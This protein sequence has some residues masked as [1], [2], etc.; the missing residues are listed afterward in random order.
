M[1]TATTTAVAALPIQT[2]ADIFAFG[3]MLAKSNMFGIKNPADGVVIAATC[4]QEKISFLKFKETF[5][6][7]NGVPAI[8]AEA[9]LAN[10]LNLGGE[11][12]ILER[13][14]DIVSIK[15]TYKKATYISTLKWQ[16][17][18]MEDYTKNNRGGL[19]D[20]WSTPRRRMQMMW[21][22]VVSDG[23]RVVCPLATRGSYTPEEVMDFE[24]LQ[25]R[26]V[27][28]QE[29]PRPVAPAPQHQPL[30]QP[31]PIAEAPVIEA[32]PI[33]QPAPQPAQQPVAQPPMSA[34]V[35]PM[36]GVDYSI[37]RA[38]GKYAG[39]KWSDVPDDMLSVALRTNSPYIKDGDRETINGILNARTQKQ[40]EDNG[41]G[42]H[43]V[44]LN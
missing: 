14:P 5:H 3:D 30:P 8:K 20:N 34:E 15:L 25:P 27:T 2:T 33:A 19:K 29:A 28:P 18:Q 1:P 17:A 24:E 36:P 22:R 26:D 4:L 39:V 6:L 32:V 44:D 11:Y 40:G 38:P 35:P 16:D 12:E 31:Q 7:I 13:T 9:M 42:Y 43:P 23:V 41:T 37:C 10:L 21:A